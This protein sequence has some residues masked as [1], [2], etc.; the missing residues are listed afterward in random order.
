MKRSKWRLGL[1]AV[2]LAAVA[3]LAA[4][5]NA[6]DSSSSN[7]DGDKVVVDIFQFKVEFKDQFESIAEKYEEEN[8]NIDINIT[9]VGGGEDY[10]AAL[11]S[12]FASGSEPAIYNIGGPQD[13]E[14]WND[15]LADLTDTA[16]SKAALAG[17]LEGVTKDSKVLGLPYNQEGYGFI[18]NKAI[19][20]KAGVDPASIKDFATLEAAVKVL[21]EK[22]ADLGIEA[23]FAL[24]GK[25]TWVTGL[26]LANT[27]I[28]PEFNNDV[29][30][31]FNAKEI[32]FEQ[33]AAFQKI[34]DLQN[35]YSVQPTV[36]LDY[37]KQME[38]LFSNGKVAIVQQ[39]NW[40]YGTIEGIDA[41][42][43]ENGI[44]LM[45][46][47]IDGYADA[48]LPVGV[49]MYWGVNSNKDDETVQ[50]AKDFLDWLYT[51]DEGKTA[52]LEDFKFIPAYEGYDSSKISDP[53]SKAV[54]EYS[55]K[56]E[57]IGWVFMGYPTDWGQNQLGTEIQKYLSEKASWDEVLNKA[58]EAWKSSRQ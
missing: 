7:E 33:G 13:V 1:A 36:S 18:Y 50:A 54:Y 21:D 43:A 9:T 53:L 55:A 2:S 51:S 14:D 34:L 42:L 32:T 15:K 48:K 41:D 10:G 56:G 11:R 23:V 5:G 52:V 35:D 58:T 17:T 29:T 4:C 20:E 31:A 8:E 25:E 40:V 39:G 49:P 45:P 37:S 28:A 19:F 57:T 26:H 30:E 24:P 27:F 46:I 38:E 16:A 3:S 12:K 6:G 47:P 44:G 22:K